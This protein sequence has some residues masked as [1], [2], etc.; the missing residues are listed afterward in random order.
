MIRDE[1][2][3]REQLWSLIKDIKFGMLTTRHADG[4]LRSRP[5]TTQNSHLDQDAKLWFFMSRLGEAAAELQADPSVCM[6][7]ADTG[8]DSYVSVSG[9]ARVSNDKAKKQ[10]L[11]SPLAKAWFPQGIDDPDLLLVRI[12]IVD[13]DCWD[14]KHSKLVQLWQMASAAVSGKPP[15]DMGEHTH[16]QV[17]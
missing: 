9:T 8:S 13:A 7:Y 14:V 11:W 4:R 10:E 5:M 17:R 3:A 6:V 2:A 12:D 1:F 15:T 16:V